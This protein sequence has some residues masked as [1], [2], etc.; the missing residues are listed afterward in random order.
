MGMPALY[1]DDT[2]IRAGDQ[3]TEVEKPVEPPLFEEEPVEDE[4]E[5]DEEEK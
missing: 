3:E 1:I 4:P 2:E 5:E